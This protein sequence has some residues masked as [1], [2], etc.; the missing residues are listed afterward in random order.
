MG[1]GCLLL[2][3]NQVVL[4]DVLLYVVVNDNA[5]V[6]APNIIALNG[7]LHG[8][9]RVLIPPELN[10][11]EFLETCT[12]GLVSGCYGSISTRAAGYQFGACD[13]GM[14]KEECDAEPKDGQFPIWAPGGCANICLCT[15]GFGCY[16]FGSDPPETQN[17]CDCSPEACEGGEEVCNA[18]VGTHTWTEGCR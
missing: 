3:E 2:P 1:L 18:K 7:V 16:Q 12:S 10:V 13:C 5:D 4:Q 8:I 17:N 6:V 9:D 11:E 14:T 15:V